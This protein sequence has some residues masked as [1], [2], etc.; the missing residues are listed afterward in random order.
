MEDLRKQ[1]EAWLAAE[2]GDAPEYL[3]AKFPNYAVFR[4]KDNRKWYALVAVVPRERLGLAGQAPLPVLVVKCEPFLK[5]VLL[6]MPGYLPAY[7]MN[8][9]HWITVRLDGS[10][11]FEKIA[12]HLAMSR[13]LAGGRK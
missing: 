13:E 3:W 1:I 6:K 8:K 4:R 7:H 10:V 2:N 12:G 9:E 5:D 11:P